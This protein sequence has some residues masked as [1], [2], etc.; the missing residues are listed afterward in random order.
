[1]SSVSDKDTTDILAEIITE[2]RT[3]F[4]FA[5]F[6]TEQSRDVILMRGSRSQLVGLLEIISED[7]DE[8]IHRKDE[9]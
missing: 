6:S 9:E 5:C 1:M 3:P 4:I 7:I 8:Y 2:K